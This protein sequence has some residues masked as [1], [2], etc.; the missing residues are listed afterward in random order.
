M[1]R[2]YSAQKRA[3]KDWGCPQS[4]KAGFPVIPPLHHRLPTHGVDGR[5]HRVLCSAN[6]LGPAV[7]GP[8]THHPRVASEAIA[9][10]GPTPI[11]WK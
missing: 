4:G 3:I 7:G 11:Q 1:G 2:N 8:S 9:A 6:K 10:A 5:E